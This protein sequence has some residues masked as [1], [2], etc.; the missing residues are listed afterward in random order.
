MDPTGANL[1]CIIAMDE[2]F[3]VCTESSFKSNLVAPIIPAIIPT[4]FLVLHQR[5]EYRTVQR[6]LE[7]TLT[8]DLAS[9]NR[10]FM[11]HLSDPSIRYLYMHL[12][13]A[14]PTDYSALFFCEAILLS[15]GCL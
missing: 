9:L 13:P 8:Y 10:V 1:S 12:K 15:S 4:D 5:L 7:Y 3:Q 14:R 2:A 11:F 6:T